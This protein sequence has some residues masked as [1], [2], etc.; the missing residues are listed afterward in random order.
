MLVSSW[1]A[2]MRAG[3]IG[4]VAVA[5][6]CAPESMAQTPA[7]SAVAAQCL[8]L[9]R[10][11]G[12]EVLPEF[13][14]IDYSLAEAGQ[15]CIDFAEGYVAP[16][17]SRQFA[18]IGIEA[19]DRSG[20]GFAHVEGL[21][22]V[23]SLAT[24]T[25]PGALLEEAV[26]IQA[27]LGFDDIALRFARAEAAEAYEQANNGASSRRLM[28]QV[29]S[30]AQAAAVEASNARGRRQCGA[31]DENGTQRQ[32]TVLFGTNRQVRGAGDMLGD[33][34]GGHGPRLRYGEAVVSVPR[35]PT[36]DDLPRQYD[37]DYVRPITVTAITP[38]ANQSGFRTALQRQVCNERRE[39]LVFIH[40]YNTSF[41]GSLR[42]AANLA[43][44][45]ELDGAAVVYS[46]PSRGALWGYPLDGDVAT[47]DEN[48]AELTSILRD[49][50]TQQGVQ[51]V[52]VVAHSM[53]NRLLVRALQRMRSMEPPNARRHLFT[54]IVFAS[55]DVAQDYFRTSV[56]DASRL[57]GRLTLYASNDDRALVV[58]RF[59]HLGGLRAGQ[60]GANILV[61][62][63]DT[64][65]TSAAMSSGY[66]HDDF[67][68]PARDDLRGLLWFSLTPQQRC[69]L[70]RQDIP[71]YPAPMWRFQQQASCNA[72]P[73]RIALSYLRRANNNYAEAD[74]LLAASIHTRPPG[75]RPDYQ[76]A[77]TIIT[78]LASQ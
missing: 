65:D 3:N 17:I 30:A 14:G 26:N 52:Y 12:L 19:L 22:R 39:A 10:A 13:D 8:A 74:R 66:E 69:L 78:R 61:N 25:N 44:V 49:V 62:G 51:R 50:A 60:T 33:Y 23:A 2:A 6:L 54:E 38:H 11:S 31:G 59:L 56:E 15:L 73:F 41:E 24:T 36:R 58:S 43:S 18:M 27:S 1:E 29:E 37:R 71:G 20:D 70:S 45:L 4:I 34:R 72:A 32:V 67:V 57:A 42:A 46:W 16:N 77:R 21:R 64:I 48:V 47:N 55:P 40:G 5:L 76:A 28:G 9:A 68:G 75:A 53:G 7:G 63:L 35:M